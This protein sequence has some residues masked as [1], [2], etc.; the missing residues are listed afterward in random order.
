MPDDAEP[1]NSLELLYDLA[2]KRMDAQMGQIDGIDTKLGLV[3]GFSNLATGV[4]GGLLALTSD[5][6]NISSATWALAAVGAVFYIVIFYLA[7]Q[8]YIFRWY[9]YAPDLKYYFFE[10]FSWPPDSTKNQI[11][12]DIVDSVE[13][14]DRIINRKVIYGR[15]AYGLLFIQV[16]FLTLALLLARS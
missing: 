9:K 1:A 15:W 14:N 4:L 7:I 2:L 6:G 12:A 10:A 13:F 8:G 3:F 5:D 11:A 16:I